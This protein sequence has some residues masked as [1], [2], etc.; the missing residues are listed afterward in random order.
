VI[1]VNRIDRKAVKKYIAQ[2]MLK[3][4]AVSHVVDLE[5]AGTM[6]LPEKLRM[7][8]HNGYNQRLSGDVQVVFKPQWFENWRTG[9][10][11]GLWND[12]DVHI[13]LIWFGWN[14]KP[15]TLYRQVYMTDIAPTLGAI[16]KVQMPNASIG[17][18]IEE[19]M[20]PMPLKSR[21]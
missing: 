17:N 12:Y 16:L 14:I 5:E 8:L 13:P 10:T 21:L 19:L 20:T 9:S 18:V 15:G 3:Q 6:A 1:N 7:M 11:H 4:T 2:F